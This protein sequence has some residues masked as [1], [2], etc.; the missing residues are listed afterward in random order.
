MPLDLGSERI[1]DL[2]KSI[3]KFFSDKYTRYAAISRAIP[4]GNYF[5]ARA[6]PEE[7]LMRV[8][9]AFSFLIYNKLFSVSLL[10][11]AKPRRSVA[12]ANH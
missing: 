1:D 4:L 12:C 2:I 8:F 7:P 5:S 9:S 6:V 11:S 10:P 3:V